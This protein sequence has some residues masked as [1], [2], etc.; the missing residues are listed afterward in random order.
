MRLELHALTACLLVML[1]ARPAAAQPGA[2][3]PP[4][5]LVTAATRQAVLDTLVDRLDRL[6]VFPEVA[7]STGKALRQRAAR[8]EYDA[9]A[10]AQAFADSLTAHLQAAS[11]DRHLRVRW[12]PEA[13]PATVASVDSV[14][15]EQAAQARDGLR[16]MN[17][18][19]ERVQRLVGNV[20]YLDLRRFAAPGLGGGE[21]AVAAMNALG[22]CDALIVD[23]RRNGGGDP[24]MADLLIAYLY[25]PWERIHVN[26]FVNRTERGF[27]TDQYWTSPWVPGPH[28]AH[29]EVYV[30]T[31]AYTFSCAEEFAY[32]LK[33]L[34]RGTIVGET[35]GGGANPGGV[36]P[37]GGGFAVFVPTG[38][39]Q[40]PVTKTN[41]EGVGVKP[42][43]A[44]P[45]DSALA[46]AHAMALE[47]LLARANGGDDRDR[48]GRALEQARRTPVDALEERY[49]RTR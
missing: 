25:E 46:V 44:V 22:G 23:L 13:I 1:G 10:S 7:R 41:W 43:V 24:L 36:R 47:K 4:D 17:C 27:E 42:D 31:S 29:R 3:T 33:C 19:F 9:L 11:H 16:L 2:P 34:K 48:L 37:L 49:R 15:P 12:S 30:L 40:N 20:G 6:Y 26:D 35:T 39:A 5:T 38:R 32:D 28:L 14:T 21:T 8:H 45:A 18:G